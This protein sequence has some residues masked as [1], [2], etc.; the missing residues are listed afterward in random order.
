[1]I[2]FFIITF[3]E[4]EKKNGQ[5]TIQE[6]SEED[7]SSETSSE[8]S[9]KAEIWFEAQ[10]KEGYACIQQT[11]SQRLEDPSE[12]ETGDEEGDLRKC[13]SSTDQEPY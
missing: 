4:E 8:I 10:D 9:F 2:P 12:Y 6:T 3:M 13:I 1:M 5:N 7:D 11:P